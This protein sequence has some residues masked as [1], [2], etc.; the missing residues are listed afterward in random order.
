MRC[1]H[2]VHPIAP[3]FIGSEVVLGSSLEDC[4]ILQL[5]ISTFLLNRQVL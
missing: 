5:V 1:I 4:Q 3:L 2:E